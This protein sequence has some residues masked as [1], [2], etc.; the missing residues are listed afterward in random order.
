MTYSDF[1]L[2]RVSKA[3]H[4]KLRQVALFP[5]V[6]AVEVPSWLTDALER[7]RPFALG[8]EKARSELIVVPVLLAS[9]ERSTYTRS[10][11][12]GQRL[13]VAPDQGLTGKCDFIL[14]SS[15]T[16]PILQSPL[17]IL[18]EAKKNDIEGGLGQCGAQMLGAR[19]FN[20]REG[21]DIRTIFGCVTTGESWQFLKLEDDTLSIDTDRYY[22]VTLGV[23]LGVF[24]AIGKG[25]EDEAHP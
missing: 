13:D 20:E 6:E 18:V 25:G 19:L 4:L 2:D 5:Q 11:Y 7:G 17:V 14:S 16:L 9:I 8:S 1:T 3:F 15:P 10:L 21:T 22:L 23:L 12:S 24:E